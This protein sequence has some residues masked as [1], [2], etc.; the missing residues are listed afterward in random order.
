MN[1]HECE[2]LILET[3]ETGLTAHR[4]AELQAHVATCPSCRQFQQAQL[5]LDAALMKSL[6]PP[7]LSPDFSARILH[8]VDQELA[9]TASATIE[10]R[11]Q[12]AEAEFEARMAELKKGSF[13]SRVLRMLDVIGLGAA[14]LLAGLL[15]NSLLPRL[16]SLPLPSVPTVW[17]G[18][19][20]Y[21]P[22]VAAALIVAAGMAL[23]RRRDLLARLRV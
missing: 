8:R 14:G 17:Q 12:A 9:R 6:R 1:C 19:M 5:R 21:A 4:Q 10:A 16:A 7:S 15:L 13:G 18:S 11:K 2:E 20:T 22:W 3:L 23:G